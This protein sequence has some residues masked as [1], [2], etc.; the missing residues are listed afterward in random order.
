[1]K[2]P[3]SVLVVIH[4]QAGQ[5]LLLERAD[6]QGFWQSVTGSLDSVD[7][8]LIETCRREVREE[9][10]LDMPASAFLDW[11]CVNR[12]QILPAWRHRYAPGVTENTEH[13]FSLCLPA[14]QAVQL[15]PREHLRYM[16]LAWRDAADRCF[17]WTNHQAVRALVERGLVTAG[18]GTASASPDTAR[19]HS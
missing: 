14:E 1:M 5:V 13:L 7:E 19:S 9:T 15:A 8:P 6:H 10:G 12:Y 17:S 2:I 11:Q 4:T 16:W 3:E 18:P